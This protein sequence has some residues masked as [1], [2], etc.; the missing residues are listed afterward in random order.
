MS[1]DE[2]QISSVSRSKDVA[3]ANYNRLSR[4]YDLIAG[5]S[6]RKAVE[7]GLKLLDI[8]AGETVLEIGYGTGRSIVA[9]GQA[10]G[11]SGRVLGVDISEGM[12][13]VATARVQ[14]ASLS[15]RVALICGDATFLTAELQR[16]AALPLSPSNPKGLP[17]A[18]FMSFTLELFDTPEISAVLRECRRVLRRDG[19]IVVAAMLKKAK[20]NVMARLYDYAHEKIPKVV[21]CRPIHAGQALVDAGFHVTQRNE[22]RMWGL[23]VLVVLAINPNTGE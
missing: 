11:P 10:V 16:K 17:D 18:V 23:P 6:E 12:Y 1:K 21:D 3:K 22:M 19:R 20:R 15:D 7:C 8:Q 2:K 13:R 14:K 4:W 9:L 5:W